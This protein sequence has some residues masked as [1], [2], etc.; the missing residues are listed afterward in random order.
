MQDPY[1]AVKEEVVHSVAVVSDLHKKWRELAASA[2]KSDEFGWT[3]SEL[4]S[5]L[6]SIEWDLQDLE[7]HVSI[8]EGLSDERRAIKF[9][10]VDAA[11]LAQRKD[12]IDSVRQKI[13]MVRQ[14]VTEIALS[15]DAVNQERW[16]AAVPGQ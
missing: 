9:P 1:F 6:R 7:D 15:A 3:S 5:G 11:V 12:L 13:D 14:S 8:V 10:D 2:R 4:L 16:P